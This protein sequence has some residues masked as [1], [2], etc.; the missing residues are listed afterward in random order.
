MTCR[1]A[2]RVEPPHR[3]RVVPFVVST[4]EHTVRATGH[5]KHA[6]VEALG[7]TVVAVLAAPAPAAAQ[8]DKEQVT[9]TK[10]IAPIFQRS[11]VSCHRPGS[12][13]PMSLI[14]YEDARPW[15]RAIKQKTSRP[16]NDPERMP[17]WFIETNVGIQKFK[18][19]PSLTE[20]EIALIGRWADAG[21]PRGDPAD[22]PAVHLADREWTIGTPDLI[23]TSPS[24]TLPAVAPDFYG[25]IGPAPTG[26]TE[27]RYIKAVEFREKRVNA[28][29]KERKAGDL[30]YFSVHHAVIAATS[31]K[32][33][34]P[35]GD[36]VVDQ[37]SGTAE[38][39]R[40]SGRFSVVWELGQNA[41]IYPDV[42][43]VKLGAGSA[44]NFDL[45]THSIGTEATFAIEVAFKFH[46]KDYQPKYS[47]AGS[48]NSLTYDLDIP[49]N[50]ETVVQALY[51]M[52][53]AGMVLSFEPHLHSSGRR[54]CVEA[55]YP[56]GYQETLNCAGYNHNWVK[57]YHYEDDAAPLLPKGTVIKV[58]AWYD[59][60]SSNPRVADPRNWKGWGSRSID[61]MLFLLSRV[62]WLTDKQYEQELADRAK[63]T[64]AVSQTTGG[65]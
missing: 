49:G 56:T 8:G 31:G 20:E 36:A 25:R 21:A 27:D 6:F 16:P 47:T 50:K 52:A 15:A 22:M 42:L 1:P 54:M 35:T 63:K 2:R 24:M 32:N 30:N 29:T 33:D 55:L 39:S 34:K 9:F 51:P 38:E 65:N 59:N 53:R 18:D 17:P 14:T 23:V 11:C 40:G 41:T 26:L 19:N 13:A 3:L 37:A 7:L 12:I 43:G 48:F 10:Q 5:L 4:E 62:V 46:P 45:H 58:T 61:D 44:L 28:A 64:Q 60:T 57:V